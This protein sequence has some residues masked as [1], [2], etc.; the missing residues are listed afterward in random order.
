MGSILNPSR[1]PLVGGPP[2]PRD[3][4]IRLFLFL[5]WM[6]LV[7]WF[8]SGHVFWRDEVRGFSLALSGSN[9]VEMLRNVHGEGH[10]AL[11]YL[12]LRGAHNI[13]PYREVLPVMGALFGFLAMG[14]FVFRSP[15]R[16]IIV[17]LVLFSLYGAF[18]YV[19]VARNYGLS[20]FVM[21]V[22][23]ALYHRIKGTLWFGLL[24]LILC[25]TSVLSCIL[26]AA[27]LLF[28]VI[29]AM[30]ERPTMTR[31]SWSVMFGNMV[32]AAIGAWICFRTVYP[33]F[34]DAAVSSNFGTFTA[35]KLIDALLD[36]KKGFWNLGLPHPLLALVFC[37]SLIRRPAAFCAAIAGFIALKMFFYLVYLSYYRHE[38]LFVVFLLA[39]HWMVAKGAGG[40][41]SER[42]ATKYVQFAG[43]W[44]FVSLL[45]SQ[46]LLLLRPIYEQ[47][48]GVP[49]SRSADVAELLKRPELSGA[50]IM[51]DPDTML[52]PLPYYVE[53][54]LWMLRQERFGKVVQLTR[55]ARRELSL[56]DIL[57]DAARLHRASGRPILYLSHLRLR[58]L[59]KGRQMV[60]F[61][62]A[63]I[64]TPENVRRFRASTRRVASFD[65][66]ATG[67]SY[68][69]FVYPR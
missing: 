49:Y 35:D 40:H 5:I 17:G 22:I 58:S 46:S 44:A 62:H 11:W 56:D 18:E 60:L 55:N 41:D 2:S 8:M 42:P 64:V 33:T 54:P 16:T 32:L 14:V 1:S 43:Q 63:T 7:A 26:A 34:N 29:E 19:V 31:R 66:A 21:F 57:A 69:V 25:N 6:V 30:G 37:F 24:L 23:A 67:E 20:A 3:L 12:I 51:A 27:F 61:S 45:F 9:V 68:D 52:E 65:R 48:V 50:I 59:S 15:F 13:T 38:I 53:N 4:R 10:P 28:R 36:W 47:I 39:L